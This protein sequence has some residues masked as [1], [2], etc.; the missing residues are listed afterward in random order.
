VKRKGIGRTYEVQIASMDQGA[1]QLLNWKGTKST[2]GLVHDTGTSCKGS[3]KLFSPDHAD[4]ALAVWESRIDPKILGALHLLD[5]LDEGR[6]GLLDEVVA[7]YLALAFAK[8]LSARGCLDGLGKRKT[9]NEVK[10][11]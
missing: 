4:R 11:S 8:C 10:P 5:K 9:T 2:L 3:L 1:T 7:S 6:K